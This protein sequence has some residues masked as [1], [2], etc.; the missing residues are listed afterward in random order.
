[1]RDFLGRE[2]PAQRRRDFFDGDAGHDS[3]LWQGLMELGIGGLLVPEALG[4]AVLGLLD[5]VM[6]SVVLGA[7]A[8]PVPYIGLVLAT[9]AIAA[10]QS[11][12]AS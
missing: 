7:A 11:L 6:V 12:T 3:S 10:L 4:G 9:L 5:A 2:Y 1:M 8:F